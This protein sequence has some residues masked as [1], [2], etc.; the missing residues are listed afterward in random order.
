MVKSYRVPPLFAPCSVGQFLKE[1]GYSSS[2]LKRLRKEGGVSVNGSFR[3]NIDP[4]KAGDVITVDFP[5]KA[6]V[7]PPNGDLG[8]S[9]VFEND[10]LLI[11]EKPDDILVHPATR[12][13]NDAL[14]NYFSY[15]HPGIPFRPLGR[16]DRHTTGLCLIA[17]NRLTAVKLGSAI[18]KDYFAITQGI[19]EEDR[20]T[21]NAPLLRVGGSV[22]Q[23]K[24]D[25]A[26]QPSVTHYQVLARGHKHTLLKLRLET[27]RTHQIRVHMAHLGHPLAGDTLYGGDTQYI[28]RQAL[29]CGI[30]SFFHQGQAH[31]IS[32]PLPRDMKALVSIMKSQKN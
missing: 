2:M 28:R 15:L 16:L 30:M 24:V 8:I 13:F 25:P 18:E 5:D 7:L 12:D 1:Q 27:G 11:F 10:D 20:G 14:G 4:V 17:K 31:V 22:I 23:R 21:V 26:G 9:V 6:P 3:R 32:S 29:H 19:I